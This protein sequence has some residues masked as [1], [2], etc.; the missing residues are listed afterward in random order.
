MLTNKERTDEMH[1]RAARLER[2][3]RVH[4][5]CCGRGDISCAYSRFFGVY[6][7]IR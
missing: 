2:E 7:R 5:R 1:R 6:V 4:I 3:R